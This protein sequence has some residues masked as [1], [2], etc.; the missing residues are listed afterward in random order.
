MRAHLLGYGL[1]GGLAACVD[2]GGFH[3]LAPHLPGVWPAAALSFA[4]AAAVNYRLS[5]AWVFKSQ[6]RSLSRAALFLGAACVG[7]VVNTALTWALATRWALHPT[8]AKAGGVATAFL[9]NF[10]LNARVVFAR[11]A[12]LRCGDAA[13]EVGP[14]V[15]GR[16]TRQAARAAAWRSHPWAR[17]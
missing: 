1:T 17:E 13:C 5:S 16:T 6:W 9:L 14:P 3:L 4:L 11:R 10:T 12:N 8:L 7:L 15:R 2:I